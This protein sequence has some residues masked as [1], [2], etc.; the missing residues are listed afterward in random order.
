MFHSGGS[1]GGT[2]DPKATVIGD[3]IYMTYV[4]HAGYWPMRTALTSIA[5]QDFLKKR[6]KWKHPMLMSAPDVGSKSVIILPEKVNGNY[7]IYHRHWPNIV[8]DKVPELEFGEGKRWL[9]SQA[10]IRPRASFWDSQKISMGAAPIKTP[11]GWLA[12][13]NAVDRRDSSR[14]KIGAMLLDLNDPSK[15]IARCRKPIL[16]PDEWYENDGKS[17]VAYPGGLVE[18]NGML[19]VYYGGGDKV[20]CVATISTDELV[21]QLLKDAE[22]KV[23]VSKVRFS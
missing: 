20:S 13:Y 21:T 8:V 19:Y 18:R 3:R 1:W 2:E 14:Y 11:H 5:V 23:S 15:V 17:G 9:G 7:Y 4:A 12:I 6:W 16:S 22:P 10:L